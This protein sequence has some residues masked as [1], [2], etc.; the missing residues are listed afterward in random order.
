MKAVICLATLGMIFSTCGP[1]PTADHNWK[2]KKWVLIELQGNPVQVSGTDK[3]AHLVFSAADK[4]YS[5]T[6]GCNRIMGTYTI[7]NKNHLSFGNSAGTKMACPDL[8]F[9]TKF[10]EALVTVDNYS[11]EGSSM[12]LKKGKE[13]IMKLN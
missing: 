6:G 4:R 3:D 1:K 10:L 7:D 2:D 13:K 5:G 12:L 8:A 11:M 9:E